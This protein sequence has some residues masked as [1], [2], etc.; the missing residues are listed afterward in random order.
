MAFVYSATLTEY[1]G[2]TINRSPAT[3][4]EAV[5]L[6]KCVLKAAGWT[7]SGSSDGTTAN[8]GTDVLVSSGSGTGGIANS[9]AWFLA[10]QP[11]AVNGYRRQMVFQRGSADTTWR[12][13]LSISGTMVGGSA[14]QTPNSNDQLFLLGGGTD[15]SP[16]FA[17]LFTNNN[18]YRWHA[19]AENTS[20]YGFWSAGYPNGGG[21]PNACMIMDGLDATPIEDSDPYVYYFSVN[22]NSILR[23]VGATGLTGES[24]TATVVGTSIKGYLRK[25]SNNEGFV[26]TPAI[27]CFAFNNGGGTNTCIPGGMGTNPYNQKDDIIPLIYIRPASTAFLNP[28]GFKGISKYLKY[29][30]SGRITGDSI[31]VTTTRDYIAIGDVFFPW[32]GDLVLI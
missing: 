25:G 14:S 2:S 10:Q 13:K 1:T 16:S 32:N 18:T 31:T 6:F 30:P 24:S 29:N 28:T 26:V 17:T 9:N 15:V 21:N 11:T 7:I 20:P 4:S 19:F 22:G 23:H 27:A 12:V 8:L 3:G 5:W